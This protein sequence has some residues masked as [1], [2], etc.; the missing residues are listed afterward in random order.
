MKEMHRFAVI[1]Q[2][3]LAAVVLLVTTAL[4]IGWTVS[5][6]A[7]SAVES[8]LV[9]RW[10]GVGLVQDSPVRLPSLIDFEFRQ[11][12]DGGLV[13][14]DLTQREP[15]EFPVQV[16]GRDIVVQM[17]QPVSS[18]RSAPTE[19]EGK[20]NAKGDALDIVISTQGLS[21]KVEDVRKAVLK[22]DNLAAQA[23]LHPRVDKRGNPVTSYTYK[24]PVDATRTYKVTTPEAAGLDRAKLEEMVNSILAQ[25]RESKT[26]SVLI[27]Q[28]GKLV[29][30]E[31]FWGNGPGDAHQTWSVVKSLTATVAGIA[32]DNGAFQLDSTLTSYFPELSDTKWAKENLAVSVRQAL[33]MASGAVIPHPQKMTTSP[34][35]VEF[36][37]NQPLEHPPGM[38]YAYDNGLPVLAGQLVAKTTGQPFDRYAEDNLFKPLGIE[39]VRWTYLADGSPNGAGGFFITPLDFSRIGQMMLDGGVWKGKRIVSEAWVAESTK[40]QTAKGDYPYGFYWHLNDATEQRFK[41]AQ[42]FMAIGALGQLIAVLPNERLVVVVTSTNTKP[43]ELLDKYIVPAI[44]RESEAAE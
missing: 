29:L 9:G 34:N 42:A 19:V 41:G 13:A 32:W 8:S 11:Q 6:N 38:K 25:T 20:L 14:V 39:K 36:M 7:D 5:A 2:W 37:L 35:M 1:Q 12:A 3:R 21:G 10:N 23:F 43:E 44:I 15:T 16:N 22:R 40:Q 26:E 30:A 18:A 4:Q 24:A 33:S 27:L 28:D 17:Q 31:Y